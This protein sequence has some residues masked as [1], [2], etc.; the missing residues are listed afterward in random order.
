MCGAQVEVA[1][2]QSM[3]GGVFSH[4][5]VGMGSVAEVVTRV[6]SGGSMADETIVS[7]FDEN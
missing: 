2:E 7:I 5:V 1:N 6:Q 3:R 4:G